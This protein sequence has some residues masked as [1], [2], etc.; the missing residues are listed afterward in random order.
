M[1]PVYSWWPFGYGWE[2]FYTHA[3][4]SV[5]FL[6]KTATQVTRSSSADRGKLSSAAMHQFTLPAAIL[7][8]FTTSLDRFSSVPSHD[9]PEGGHVQTLVPVLISPLAKL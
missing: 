1:Y 5:G 7:D 3:D 4:I 6:P 2:H 9:P 8:T